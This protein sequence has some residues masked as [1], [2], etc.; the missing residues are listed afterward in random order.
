M[1]F[2]ILAAGAV[3][4]VSSCPGNAA[5]LLQNGGFEAAPLGVA[6]VG[7]YYA[8]NGMV[9]QYPAPPVTSQYLSD[10]TIAVPGESN[11]QRSPYTNY[12]LYPALAFEGSQFFSL[13]WSPLGSVTL[14]NS[15]AQSFTLSDASSLAFSV[16]MTTENGFADST[17]QAMI[18]DQSNAIVAQSDLFTDTNGAAT[19]ETKGWAFNLAAGSYTLALHGIGAGNAW[20]VMID[21][22][23]LDVT[24]SAVP[25]PA[26]W[27]MMISG[28]AM[29]GY[30]MRGRYNRTSFL[31]N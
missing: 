11:L 3:A 14:D 18:I 15:I 16:A 26:S 13:N 6:L 8:P 1:R 10:W 5:S 7:N 19:W 17:L 27:A 24:A 12:T 30:A 22:V 23:R 4:C 31:R 20:D 28:F 9:Q 29:I 25:E 2:A 21:D